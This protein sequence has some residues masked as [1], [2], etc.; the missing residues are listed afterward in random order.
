MNLG[1]VY[2][3]A[4]WSFFVATLL[5]LQPPAPSPVQ[6]PPITRA[7][8]PTASVPPPGTDIYELTF[9]GSLESLGMAKPT[10]VAVERGYDNQ[11]FFTPDGETIWF[12]ANR[13]G[14]Q[15]DIYAFNRKTRQ[16]QSLIRTAE[17]EYSAALT[18]DG[19]GVSVIRVEPEG[20][21]RLWRFDR[22]GSNPR[23]VLAEIKP[24]GYHAWIDADQLALFVL[25][26]PATLQHARVSTGRATIVATNIGRSLHRIPNSQMVSFVHREAADNVWVKQFDAASGAITPLIRLPAGND[27]GDV[28]WMPDGTLLM[29]TG[30]KIRSWRRGDKDWRQVYDVAAHNLGAVTRMAV[31]P[32]GKS[33]A[34]VV[35]EPVR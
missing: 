7:S 1:R 27:A 24:V 14:K 31:A 21:Q 6:A 3:P 9:D 13:D 12:T 25:G 29:S 22:T 28:A 11:P 10:P 26:Q 30:T 32:D 19:T 15:T 17:S 35:A 33:L 4:M 8:Q 20:T 23:V 34:I 2:S 5:L 18:P 16:V